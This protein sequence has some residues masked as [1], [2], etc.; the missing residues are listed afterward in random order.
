M[1]I[2]FTA[3][4]TGGHVFPIIAIKR[5][6]DR[7]VATLKENNPNIFDNELFEK[8]YFFVGG[9]IGSKKEFLEKEN[10]KTKEII[11]PKW[12]R[13]FDFKNF[14]DILKA[15]IALIH[16]LFLVWQI[17]PDVIF[18]KGGPGSFFIVIAGWFYGIPV[19]LHE[20][21]STLSKTNKLSLPFS[22]KIA[23]SF[24][25]T[26]NFI[27]NKNKIL[28]TGHP[29]RQFLMNGSRER[30]KEDFD[31]DGKREIILVMGGSQGAQQINYVIIDAIFKY[32]NEYEI[33]HI[34]G[35]NNFQELYLL[36]KALL[37]EELQKYY[38]LFPMLEEEKLKNAYAAAD[39]IVSRAG[40]GALFEIAAVK[41]PSVIIPLEGSA[42]DHQT[43]NAQI[44]G[45][46]GCGVVIEK[47]NATPNVVF[48]TIKDIL[49]DKER[50]K[51]FI[52][53]C[54]KFYKSDA[55]IKIAKEIMRLT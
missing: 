49:E 15:P 2:L 42:S 11:A 41:K 40:A 38:H 46:V 54:K 23:L 17:M 20:S 13:Y 45:E 7:L 27:K 24:E 1:R 28:I 8:E 14:I 6:I 44:F 16:A 55:G 47:Q 36:T 9:M 22:K 52:E 37:D 31:L 51:Q 35:E 18:S 39:I 19:I 29:V 26:Q 48:N 5:E 32:L 34:S 4:G 25:E 43:L 30:A 33:I 12:R 21:D 53:N 10:I 50:Q 3:G